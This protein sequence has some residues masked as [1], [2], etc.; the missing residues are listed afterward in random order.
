MLDIFPEDSVLEAIDLARDIVEWIGDKKGEH[1]LLTD[2]REITTV[3]DYFVICDASNERQLNA[4][5]DN[6]REQA[7]LKYSQLPLRSEGRGESGWVLLDYGRVIVHL[8]HPDVR[9]YY[10]LE[11]LWKDAPVLLKMQ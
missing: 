9:H 11:G 6:I 1:I 10:D 8:F 2:L 4:I 5:G 3:T 7:K